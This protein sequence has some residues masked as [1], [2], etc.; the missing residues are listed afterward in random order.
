MLG[1]GE[2]PLKDEVS[3][4][5]SCPRKDH[6]SKSIRAAQT[7]FNRFRKKKR[8]QVSVGREGDLASIGKGMKMIRKHCMKFSKN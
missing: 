6:A 2:S 7:V 4:G 8:T 3:S 5:L 1:E